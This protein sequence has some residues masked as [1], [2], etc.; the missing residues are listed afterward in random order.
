MYGEPWATDRSAR[1]F[2]TASPTQPMADMFHWVPDSNSCAPGLVFFSA[3]SGPFDPCLDFVTQFV[4]YTDQFRGCGH[5]AAAAR[6]KLRRSDSRRIVA[7]ASSIPRRWIVMLRPA[8]RN[9]PRNLANSGFS[10]RV[11]GEGV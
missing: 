2:K 6:P 8:D 7:S 4:N 10:A 5:V 11:N 3:M 1:A 9:L